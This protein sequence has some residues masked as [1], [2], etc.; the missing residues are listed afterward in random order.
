LKFKTGHALQEKTLIF[1]ES[2]GHKKV[3]EIRFNKV[4]L[5]SVLI[6][7]ILNTHS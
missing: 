3:M 5:I 7:C 2:H 4:G 1:V 6:A